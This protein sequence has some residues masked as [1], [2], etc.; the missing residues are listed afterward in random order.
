MPWR[1]STQQQPAP[2]RHA[3]WRA[4]RL[5]AAVRRALRHPRG[6]TPGWLSSVLVHAALL[7]LLAL[8][9]QA[10]RRDEP[11]RE[12]R[13]SL[14]SEAPPTSAD[15]P[16]PSVAL[17]TPQPA[18]LEAVEKLAEEVDISMDEPL[19]IEAVDA[20]LEFES[21]AAERPL[22]TEVHVPGGGSLAGRTPEARARLVQ[23]RGGSAASEEA[24]RR[25]LRWLAAHQRDDG[26][27]RFNHHG[28]QCPGLCGDVGTVASTTGATALAL[29][30]FLGAGHTHTAGEYQ[31]VVEQ[32]LY[33]LGSRML[34]TPHGVDLQEGTMYAQG[35]ASIVLCEAY[36]MTDD[37]TMEKPAQ[38]AIDFILYAQDPEGG[39]WR[40]FPGQPGDTTVLGWQLM[41]LKSADMAYLLVP[42]QRFEL[43]GRFLD[44]VA[45]E[46]GALY[47]YLDR[48]PRDTTTAV[49]L[50][51]RMYL[52]WPREYTPLKRGIEHLSRL[53]PSRDNMYYNYYATQVLHHWDGPEWK[54][55]N[56]AM[57]DYLVETQ[58]RD[59]HEAGSW[60][61]DDE[62]TRSGGRLYNTAM[63]IMTLEVYYRYLPL[64][65]PVS[66]GRSF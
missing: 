52:G 42:P 66:V 61:F 56:E 17:E 4:D 64:Y 24:V 58:A 12:L 10:L 36:A 26:S 28:P 50:L 29:L 63:A 1:T 51:C 3:R 37:R 11:V 65:T 8:W 9:T 2:P 21:P 46:D 48:Q 23:Q 47:G 30:P 31:H 40:Y 39:G 59:G 13:A 35:L 16:T 22:P 54:R 14:E 45:A 5:V 55:W 20:V 41:A 19:E 43:A 27:W 38:R 34:A 60:H 32:G 18:V 62:K 44:S 49:G 6:D 53:G 33:Y 25:G 57:R 7:L 15:E